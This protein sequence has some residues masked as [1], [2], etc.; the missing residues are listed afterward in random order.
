RCAGCGMRVEV[1]DCAH[2]FG[3][4]SRKAGIPEWAASLPELCA[5]LCTYASW[6]GERLGCHQLLDRGLRPG[7]QLQLRWQ[8]VERFAAWLGPDVAI[9]SPYAPDDDPLSAMRM[10]IRLAEVEYPELV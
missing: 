5:P 2:V 6:D 3:K 7:L 4:G 8:A 1:V 10:L 9:A